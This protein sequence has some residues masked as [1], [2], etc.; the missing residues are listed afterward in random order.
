MAKQ[1]FVIKC[2]CVSA[3]MY[4]ANGYGMDT[5][6]WQRDSFVFDSNE[7]RHEDEEHF[8]VYTKRTVF[9]LGFRF[10]VSFLGI[11]NSNIIRLDTL[12]ASSIFVVTQSH[13]ISIRFS[14]AD[15][16][17]GNVFVFF[18]CKW[19]ITGPRC[20]RGRF[21]QN[22]DEFFTP[23]IHFLAYSIHRNSIWATPKSLQS[24]FSIT[25]DDYSTYLFMYASDKCARGAFEWSDKNWNGRKT[26]LSF[27]RN[28]FAVIKQIDRLRGSRT[29]SVMRI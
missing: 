7:R 4:W 23:S 13:S 22:N 25:A 3:R 16:R 27:C 11:R 15:D 21:Q 24:H 9:R 20:I 17:H 26:K 19:E 8:C 12:S 1:H 6:E 29:F 28:A 14:W 18:F 10:I 5:C 2:V